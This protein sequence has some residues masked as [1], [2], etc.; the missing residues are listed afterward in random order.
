MIN[1]SLESYIPVSI[2][3]PCLNEEQYIRDCILRLQPLR[4]RGC[5]V[6]VVDGGSTDKTVPL[7]AALADHLLHSEPGR[8]RQMNLGAGHASGEWLLFLHTDTRLPAVI[9]DWIDNLYQASFQWGF[10]ALRLSACHWPYRFIE[11]AINLRSKTTGIATGDQCVFIRRL[12]FEEH[13][14]F[15]DIPLM[16]DV[17]FSRRL[18]RLAKPWFWKN[19]VTTSSRRWEQQGILKTVLL[20]WWLRLAFFLGVSPQRL[21][22][23]YYG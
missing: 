8:A 12:L 19:P 16:E 15:A 9:K 11:R 13:K 17:E 7:A 5:E 6:I 18:R 20:M 4:E 14:G 10:F 3:I 23:I 21:H 1:A 2:I 22:K